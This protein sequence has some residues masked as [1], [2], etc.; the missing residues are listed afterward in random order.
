MKR[1]PGEPSALFSPP[2]RTEKGTIFT[3]SPSISL[4]FLEKLIV[5]YEIKQSF[6]VRQI[7]DFFNFIRYCKYFGHPLDLLQSQNYRN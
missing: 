6:C 5:F 2:M 3:I 4:N 7:P 1:A